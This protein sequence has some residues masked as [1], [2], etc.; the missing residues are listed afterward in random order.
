MSFAG[1]AATLTAPGSETGATPD[2]RYAVFAWLTFVGGVAWALYFLIPAGMAYETGDAIAHYV[3][4]REAWHHPA[5]MLHHW[6]RPVA[7]L[8]YMPSALVGLWAARVTSL[9][10]AILTALVTLQLARRLQ[11]PYVFAIP[12]LLWFQP[13]FVRWAVQPALTEVPFSL[14]MVLSAYLFVSDRL[15]PAS[16]IIGLFPLTRIEAIALT[17]LWTIYCIWRRE[18]RGAALAILPIVVYAGLYR[19][20]FGLLPGGHFPIIPTGGTHLLSHTAPHRSGW[21]FLI[22]LVSGIGLPVVIF[23]LYGAPLILRCVPRLAVFGWYASYVL[24]HAVAFGAGVGVVSALG[25]DQIRYLSPIA[26][27]ASIAAAL[28]LKSF[29]GQVGDSLERLLGRRSPP[30]Q[31]LAWLVMAACIGLVLAGGLRQKP[32]P[33]DPEVGAAEATVDWLRQHG[34]TGPGVVATHIL[35]NF[36][37]PGV[38]L[39]G[40]SLPARPGGDPESESPPPAAT[41]PVGTVVVWDSHFSGPLG[42]RHALLASNPSWSLLKTFPWSEGRFEIFRKES[43]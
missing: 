19:W 14:M 21:S 26:P 42:L 38:S 18:W 22:P 43:P 4:S 39:P 11:V 5:L 40:V 37:L 35:I 36:Y 34:M 16:L 33:V 6:G 29:V 7:T 41:M 17:G 8:V 30:P 9:I 15:L 23:A 31:T 12:V 27:A 24:V 25:W 13:W 1:R 28:G 32:T 3:I 20:T 2:R 10:L